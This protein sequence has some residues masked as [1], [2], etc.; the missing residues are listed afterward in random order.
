MK[1]GTTLPARQL[2]SRTSQ[3]D[4]ILASL[5]GDTQAF[6]RLLLQAAGKGLAHNGPSSRRA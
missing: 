4:Q 6:L 3:P 2:R 1:E 5:D